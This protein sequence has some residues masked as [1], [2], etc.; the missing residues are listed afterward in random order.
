MKKFH[1]I[2][3]SFLIIMLAL[4]ACG[5]PDNIS[6][7]S[8]D[9]S[10][11]EQNTSVNDLDDKNEAETKYSDTET[12]PNSENNETKTESG[13]NESEPIIITSHE[14]YFAVPYISTYYFNPKPSITDN[15]QIPLYITDNE[16]SEYLK[17]DTSATL[18][19]IYTVDGVSSS[20]KDIPLGDYLLTIG[21][22]NEGMHTFSVQAVDKKT[23]LKSHELFNELWVIDPDKER[24]TADQ[25]YSMTES[26]LIK[27]NINNQNSTEAS[28]CIHTRDGLNQLF[29]DVQAKGY[30]KI[31]LLPGTYRI[32][33]EKTDPA[34]DSKQ[35]FYIS[36][37]THFT[38]D[39]NG[40]TFKLDTILS[41]NQGCIVQINDAVDSHLM[42]GTLE[43]DR[44]ERK[45]LGLE[46]DE[47]NIDCKGEPINTLLIQGC[48]YS[49]ASNL[50]VK[51]TTG[52]AVGSGGIFGPEYTF[53]SQV[54]NTAIFD[55]R[56]V[57]SDKCT[58]SSM[59]D[60]APIIAWDEFDGYVYVAHLLG[61]KGIQGDSPIEYISF[62]D[63]NQN[64]I[65]T[66]IGYQ[67]RKI[68][69]PTD[70]KYLRAT[71]LGQIETTGYDHTVTVYTQHL[72]DYISYQNIDFYDTRTTALVASCGNNIL[73]EGCTYTRCGSSIT[74]LAVDFEEGGEECQDLY[75]RNN[76]VIENADTTTGTVV[77]CAGYNHVY[78]NNVGH[79]IEIRNRVL[80]GVVRD[81]DDKASNLIWFLGT[82]KTGKYG[83]VYNNDC[84]YIQ[85][86]DASLSEKS[87][88]LAVSLKVKNC[89][90]HC[91]S[92][93]EG[94]SA[95]ADKV[96]YEHCLFP[97]LFGANA[98][99]YDCTIQPAGELGT[100]LRFYHCTFTTMND[101]AGE[102]SFDLPYISNRLFDNCRFVGKTTLGSRAY[103]LG[104]CLGSF[105]Q[106]EFDDLTI[107]IRAEDDM[108]S[109]IF[110]DCTINSTANNLIY[111]GA[112]SEDLNHI[113]LQF[114]NCQ[115]SQSGEGNL[116][117]FYAK[118][119]GDSKILFDSCSI[120]K[121]QGNLLKFDDADLDALKDKISL[122]IRFIQSSVNTDLAIDA[123]G[124]GD[125]QIRIFYK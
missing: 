89:T 42:N 56:E 94:V 59:I 92:Y 19:L 54:T 105:S 14:D 110:E 39:M 115:I 107:Y 99:F 43:G 12:E 47:A 123:A 31:I 84:G 62:Y 6:E 87:R 33:G 65:D 38:V 57:E 34:F 90:V 121:S 48:K 71:F 96:I 100:D 52:H 95:V 60:L 104:F 75:Y 30:R 18:D 20:M 119:N 61:Y 41:D 22:L 9:T 81:T 49:S 23:G 11:Q 77:D 17:N 101:D 106:C 69:V 98:T 50:I 10:N 91:G 85:F 79:A 7:N 2:T 113:D 68:K 3:I 116:M 78:E 63:E 25:T 67:Y 45:A 114:K 102:L 13:N 72:G 44:F 4:T 36:V 55:G 26:D 118:P 51:N 15:I 108:A 86:S 83:R 73:I 27:Y 111:V 125:E 103:R 53:I 70:A 117:Y 1:I 21:K 32:N 58:T 112:F 46:S 93:S 97:N 29:A 37:P 82:D 16:Q 8:P 66:I 88:S 122:D 109:T 120:N 24:I 35:I 74:P 80:G 64:Y 124:I 28:D 5:M 40:S 76:C